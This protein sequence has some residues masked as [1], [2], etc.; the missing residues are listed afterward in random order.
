MGQYRKRLH[1]PVA[2]AVDYV[3]ALVDALPPPTAISPRAFGEDFKLR[4]LFVSTDHL[5]ETLGKFKAVRT[6]LQ[7]RE[8]AKPETLFA[9]LTMAWEERKV[10]GM[11]LE[12]DQVRRDVLQVAVNFFN[13]RCLGPTDNEADTRRELKI[14]AFDFLVE[15][16]LERLLEER[17][18]RRE[19]DHQRHL[20]KQKLDV[21]RSGNWGLGPMLS[22]ENGDPPDLAALEAEIARIDSEFGQ[23][24]SDQLGLE[25][26]LA[27][28]VDVFA[29]PADWLAAREISLR[30]DSRGIKVPE[31]S[32]SPAKRDRADRTLLRDG[33]A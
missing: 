28:I 30:L 22:E 3:I 26:G 18:K 9:L 31:G 33:R 4:A 29:R 1:E 15:K 25:E 5:V 20:L 13:H 21:M 14:R 24:R 7:G 10:L 12:G 11:E 8:G 32:E 6:Y 23:F 2:C 19:L 27:C 17:G 16:S